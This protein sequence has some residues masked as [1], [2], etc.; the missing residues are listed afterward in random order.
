[1]SVEVVE[2]RAQR[3]GVVGIDRDMKH[4]VGVKVAADTNAYKAGIEGRISRL[5]RMDKV[6]E[7]ERKIMDEARNYAYSNGIPLLYNVVGIIMGML[8]DVI[9]GKRSLAEKKINEVVPEK[10]RE[11]VRSKVFDPS[12]QKE[13]KSVYEIR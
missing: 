7:I 2:R 9:L 10:W 6:T 11:F 4:T 1:M 12:L 8:R 3:A 13:F 5:P